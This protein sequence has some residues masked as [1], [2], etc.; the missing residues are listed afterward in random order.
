M[1]LL[2][3]VVGHLR[4][5]S[6][7]IVTPPLRPPWK[8]MITFMNPFWPFS[9]LKSS[10]LYLKLKAGGKEMLVSECFVLSS[11]E[12]CKLI[13]FAKDIS[14]LWN[15]SC[16]SHHSSKVATK[17]HQMVLLVDGIGWYPVRWGT[18]LQCQWYHIRPGWQIHTLSPFIQRLDDMTIIPSVA[19]WCKI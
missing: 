11:S 6:S 7:S 14:S 12:V 10:G 8:P 15:F 17:E 19:P 2:F 18:L 9:N 16:I 5:V 4:Y 1:F 3:L 13:T